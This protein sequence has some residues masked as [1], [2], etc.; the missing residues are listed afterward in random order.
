MWSW[1][2]VGISPFSV[3]SKIFSD[4]SPSKAF[5]KVNISKRVHPKDLYLAKKQNKT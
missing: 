2:K 3:L 1:L 4:V 5:F